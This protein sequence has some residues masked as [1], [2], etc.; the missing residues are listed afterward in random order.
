[1]MY[2]AFRPTDVPTD[3]IDEPVR[4]VCVKPPQ[5]PQVAFVMDITAKRNGRHA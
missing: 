4:G 1:M 3:P 5:I 2:T